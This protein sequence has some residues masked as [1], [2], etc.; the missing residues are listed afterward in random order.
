MNPLQ[1]KTKLRV[2][3][4]LSLVVVLLIFVLDEV[5]IGPRAT[6]LL[7]NLRGL[8]LYLAS[9]GGFCAVAQYFLSRGSP[10]GA[11]PDWSLVLA[12]NWAPLLLGV[13]G[14]FAERPG[15]PEALFVALIAAACSCATAVLAARLAPRPTQP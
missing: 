15:P 6:F 7:A 8:T 2:A 13:I 14:W 9:I 5:F 3:G 12:L 10:R 4:T 1:R 11:A